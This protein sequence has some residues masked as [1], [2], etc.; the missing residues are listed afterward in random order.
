MI[1]V[2]Y[3]VFHHRFYSLLSS[4]YEVIVP[5]YIQMANEPFSSLFSSSCPF[6]LCCLP[7]LPR[8][9]FLHQIMMSLVCVMLLFVVRR[10]HVF[11]EIRKHVAK[12][13]ILEEFIYSRAH[14][15]LSFN[16]IHQ[17]HVY[18]CDKNAQSTLRSYNH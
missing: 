6:S 11:L 16:F 1:S 15:K 17:T 3:V 5:K 9:V 12:R 2:E 10:F 7:A 4:C 18:G 13:E 8:F 14:V